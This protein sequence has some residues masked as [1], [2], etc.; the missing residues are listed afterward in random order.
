[1]SDEGGCNAGT[2]GP[3]R[4]PRPGSVLAGVLLTLS[5]A[6]IA[7]AQDVWTEP[8]PGVRHLQRAANYE[9]DDRPAYTANVVIIDLEHP[10]VSL[11][12]T[13][14]DDR[15]GIVSDFAQRNE[16]QVAWNANFYANGQTPCGM[17]VGGGAAWDNAY[18]ECQSSLAV[19]ADNRVSIFESADPLTIPEP[20]MR[21]VISGLPQPIVQNGQPTFTYGCATHCAYHPRTGIGYDEDRT[22]LIVV[23]VD[24]RSN[25]SVGAGLDDLAT[26]LIEFGAHQAINLDGGGSST[27]FVEG[28]GGVVNAPSDGNQR[29]VCCHMGLRVD[30]G[31]RW[32]AA[33]LV[34]Q[35][36]DLVLSHNQKSQAWVEYRN[37]GRATWAAGGESPMR[38][39]TI[40]PMDRESAMAHESWFAP[41]RAAFLEADVAPGEVA[42]FDFA[43]RGP[44]P[45][46]YLE[47]FA[48]V[49]DG[50]AW[51]DDAPVR[52]NVRV[53][54]EPGGRDVGGDAPDAGGDVEADAEPDL[55]R[56]DVAA[57]DTPA[58]VPEDAPPGSRSVRT[59]EGCAQAGSADWPSFFGR[60]R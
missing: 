41:N 34:A 52:W 24:G 57:T 53:T 8:H 20:W 43:V 19:G 25:L 9:Y 50:V 10:E 38:L 7:S 54:S 42:R 11:H 22:H 40:D 35:S 15:S 18:N 45:E 5:L 47:S 13:R 36:P 1:M 31:V 27:L 21:E 39:G 37:T 12:A 44:P 6:N 60:R 17:M 51:I 33:E 48:P 49:V 26:L 28:D 23:V 2:L 32:Y 59:K 14:P 29:G 3:T 16:L 56:P 58:D 4:G 30:P 46:T 55:G